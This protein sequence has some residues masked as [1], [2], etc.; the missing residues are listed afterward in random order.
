MEDRSGGASGE[1]PKGAA[2]TVPP[3]LAVIV[4]FPSLTAVANPEEVIVVTP[5]SLDAHNT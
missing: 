3:M 1:T 4:E 5:T 2:P